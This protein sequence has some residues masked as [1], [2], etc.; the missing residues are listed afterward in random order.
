MQ[1]FL[2]S[3]SISSKKIGDRFVATLPGGRSVT[4]PDDIASIP[5]PNGRLPT[6][7]DLKD[8][9][10]FIT[11]GG[12]G[13]GAY[14]TIAFA[15]QGAKVSFVSLAEPTVDHTLQKVT[16]LS[17]STP[18]C[19][20][21]DIRNVDALT[22]AIDAAEKES[23]PIDILI[24]NAARDTR[25]TLASMTVVEWEDALSINLKPQHFG[26]KHVVESMRDQGGGGS[27]I[28]MGSHSA[29]LGLEGY[30]AYLT[31]KA[32]IV[33]LTRALARELGPDGIRVNCI[34]PGWIL[35]ERQKELWVT[36][37]A[38][39]ACIESQCL[40]RA[41]N[42]WDLVGPALF[43]ASEVSGAMTGQ[44]MVVD[45]GRVML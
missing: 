22:E 21:D 17:G 20:L 16:R 42:G 44:Q 15:L 36:E 11:G 25:H 30:P 33:G 37:E 6:F 12:S 24:N 2:G 26:I 28:N 40:K 18:F 32:A 45:G 5:F 38:L 31:A 8:K 39:N 41:L 29:N 34:V 4:K 43:L 35:T 27:I 10:V 7:P 14:F 13:I 9:H 3:S 23:G 19:V 1:K